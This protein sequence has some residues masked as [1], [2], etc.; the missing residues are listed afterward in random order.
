VAVF[1]KE[2]KQSEKKQRLVSKNMCIETDTWA[3][4]SKLQDGFM[5]T[6]ARIL[7]NLTF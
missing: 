7:Y 6:I 2:K 1:I 5:K 4:L 3:L